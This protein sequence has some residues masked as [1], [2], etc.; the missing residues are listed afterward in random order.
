MIKTA[1]IFVSVIAFVPPV[2]NDLK[3]VAT[4]TTEDYDSLCQMQAKSGLAEKQ[5][6]SIKDILA[7]HSAWQTVRMEVESWDSSR[8]IGKKDLLDLLDR[9]GKKSSGAVVEREISKRVRQNQQLAA[10]AAKSIRELE[11]AK[12]RIASLERSVEDLRKRLN[13][14]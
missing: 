2:Q 12:D 5:I 6:E 4:V 14:K 1:L 9:A 13:R 10:E 11:S 8:Q 3:T 7:D